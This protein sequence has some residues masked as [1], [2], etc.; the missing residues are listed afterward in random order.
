MSKKSLYFIA[1]L[2]FVIAITFKSNRLLMALLAGKPEYYLHGWILPHS[3]NFGAGIFQF[4]LFLTAILFAVTIVFYS[5]SPKQSQSGVESKKRMHP[6]LV[7][8]LIFIFVT[9]GF[10]GFLMLLFS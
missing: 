3:W 1:A 9:L 7:L 6:L 2:L 8:L 4:I 5:R 10:W